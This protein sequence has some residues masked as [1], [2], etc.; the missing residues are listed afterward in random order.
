MDRQEV[1]RLDPAREHWVAT[2]VAPSRE[3]AGIRGCR[4][5]SRYLV[6]PDTLGASTRRFEDFPCR[7][8]C[9]EWIMKNRAALHRTLPGAPVRPARLA[10]WLLG[11]E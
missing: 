3:W 4:R 5:G 11:L 6:D 9:L 1:D 7:A 8:A 2:V 10:H